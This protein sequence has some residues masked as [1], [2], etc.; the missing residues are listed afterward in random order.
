MYVCALFEC[1]HM[2]SLFSMQTSVIIDITCELEMSGTPTHYGVGVIEVVRGSASKNNSVFQYLFEV[3]VYCSCYFWDPNQ[4][5]NKHSGAF[6]GRVV[7]R[8][9]YKRQ[10]YLNTP[11]VT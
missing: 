6:C 1:L 3:E 11:V 5:S 9:P 4:I 10:T 8:C 2:Y 7:T